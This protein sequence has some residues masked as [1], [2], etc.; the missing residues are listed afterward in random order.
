MPGSYQ[1]DVCGNPFTVDPTHR[2]GT[3]TFYFGA[4]G[5]KATRAPDNWNN[6][7]INPS[8]QFLRCDTRFLKPLGTGSP[9]V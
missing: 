7:E 2:G 6:T 8:G 5:F 3:A 9:F 1:S 4:K